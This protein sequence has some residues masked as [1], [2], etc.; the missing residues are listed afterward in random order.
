MKLSEILGWK[1]EAGE[2]DSGEAPISF[3]KTLGFNTALSSC[4]REID[5]AVLAKA[6]ADYS[7]FESM[8]SIDYFISTMPKWMKP[9]ERK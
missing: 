5:K 6:L 4:D 7:N 8:G 1:E 3:G 9:T 2:S